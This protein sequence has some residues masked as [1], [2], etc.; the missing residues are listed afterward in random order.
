MII[1]EKLLL[2]IPIITTTIF[3]LIKGYLFNFGNIYLEWLV[4]FSGVFSI[5]IIPLFFFFFSFKESFSY[6]T[7]L[8]SSLLFIMCY[9]IT[10]GRVKK[11]RL[12]NFVILIGLILLNNF[13]GFLLV[14]FGEIG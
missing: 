7:V 6:I 10:F 3:T 12:L 8:I 2:T 14:I 1:A 4:I 5:I 13:L 9:F 11:S